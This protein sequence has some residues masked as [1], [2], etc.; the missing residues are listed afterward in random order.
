MATKQER[1]AKV[2]EAN[3]WQEG[4]TG[5]YRSFTHPLAQARV[6]LGKAGAVRLTR[7]GIAHSTP[8]S[9]RGKQVMLNEGRV[10]VKMRSEAEVESEARTTEIEKAKAAVEKAEWYL[11]RAQERLR[12]AEEAAAK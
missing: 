11:A 10:P 6:L 2:L 3:G 9:D 12:M 1:Y 4:K 8:L 7:S 5:K